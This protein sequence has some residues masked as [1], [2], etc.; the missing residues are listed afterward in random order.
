MIDV[1][2]TTESEIFPKGAVSNIQE[3]IDHTNNWSTSNNLYLN[4]DKCKELQIS[5][6]KQSSHFQP[7]SIGEHRLELITECKLLGMIISDD[8][9]WNKHID[10]IVSRASKII[11]FLVQIKRAKV[12]VNNLVKF[13]KTCIRSL[14]EYCWAFSTIAFLTISICAWK[15]YKIGVCPLFIQKPPM[16]TL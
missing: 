5:F 16:K 15:G 2:D 4:L 7:L 8:L 9:K 13:Y 6:S 10:N 11:Y 12:E 1:D 3:S 14:L